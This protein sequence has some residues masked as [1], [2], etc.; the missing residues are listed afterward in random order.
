M[1]FQEYSQA[2]AKQQGNSAGP[3][4]VREF[5]SQALKGNS[6]TSLVLSEA[7]TRAAGPINQGSIGREKGRRTWWV[8]RGSSPSRVSNVHMSSGCV[9][10]AL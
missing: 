3:S 9:L 4:E 7:K 6:H 5:V 10:L 1:P 8:H 2:A